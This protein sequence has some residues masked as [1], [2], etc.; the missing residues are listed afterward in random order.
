MKSE[1][2]L[3]PAY[4]IHQR[5]KLSWWAW[6]LFRLM[7]MASLVHF[8]SAKH[9]AIVGGIVWHGLWLVPAFIV[10]PYIIKG[11][12]P[13]ALLMT[14]M[15]TFIYLGGSGM[16]ALKYGFGQEWGLMAVWLVDFLLLAVVNLWLFMLLKRLP[17]MNG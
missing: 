9:P 17:K 4:P 2:P 7:G 10:T 12:S 1:K 14:I 8:L 13:Y 3:K 15:L 5:L 6:L 11:K 16:V